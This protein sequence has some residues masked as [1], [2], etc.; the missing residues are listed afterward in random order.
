MVPSVETS[1][2]VSL[3][4]P[5]VQASRQPGPEGLG[6]IRHRRE[7]GH[8]AAVDPR[9]DLAGVVA[10]R[11]ELDQASLELGQLEAGDVQPGVVRGCGC[12]GLS[13]KHSS[14]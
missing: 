2:R 9:E 10:R 7:I 13:L 4:V 1:L 5:T 8:A 14:A 6:Q 3:G 11:A 12:H